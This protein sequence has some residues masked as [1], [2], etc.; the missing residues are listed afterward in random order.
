MKQSINLITDYLR[1]D[2]GISGAMH[3]TEQISWLLF[4]K[5]LDDYEDRESYNAV[6]NGTTYDFILEEK[7]RWK[8]WTQLPS[9]NDIKDFVNNE[10]FP[11]LA[12]FRDSE[13]DYHSMKYKIGEIFKFINNRIESGHTIKDITDEINKLSFQ[14]QEDLFELS[15]VY[16][17]LLQGMGNDGWNS[18]EF[19]TPRSVIKIM[20]EAISP[21][22]WEKI[23]DPAAGSC[24]FLIEAFNF[25]KPKIS[26]D[27]E[28]EIL[29]NETFFANE[30]T[31]L[32]YTMG[33]MNMILHGI[34]N[35]NLNKK[36]TLT[37]NIRDIEEKDKFDIILA[38]P[39]FG[40][41]EKEEIQQNFPIKTNATE[42]LFLQYIIKILKNG[43]KSAI[44]VPEWVLFNNSNAFVEI[45][46]K[47]IQE[48]NLHSIVS[49][50]A[51]VFLP[52]SGV[53]T[54]IIFFDKTGATQDIWYYEVDL[55]RKL[56]K[57]KPINYD[58]IKH[59]P[60]L[61]KKR[62]ISENSWIVK[63]KD[64]QNF[65]LSARN[66]N[67]IKEEIFREPDEILTG[68]AENEAEIQKIL[69][70]LRNYLV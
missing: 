4:L 14:K 62:E 11:Y 28:L 69:E 25:M 42:M 66:P 17:D 16:E 23:C 21:R 10:L 5:F 31:P 67:K 15:W 52:Y 56:T 43:G 46:K 55:W 63:A 24:G 34:S 2:D 64:I 48:C 58:E 50:P 7:Y 6:L 65:D 9:G 68:M 12:T 45:K 22:I 27:K 13:N 37:T 30:K 3:Y 51:W 32:A 54:N 35:P 29:K 47:L 44:I 40:G 59:I 26:S 36:N 60:E 70:N 49:L 18:G 41:K 39:P 53:K 61:M 33:M 38:N 1:K 19:Y 20:V 57:N 8:N